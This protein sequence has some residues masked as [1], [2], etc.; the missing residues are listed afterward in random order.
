MEGLPCY[1]YTFGVYKIVKMAN[2][3]EEGKSSIQGLT[4]Y[5]KILNILIT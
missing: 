1:E 5:L 4:M 3:I 2:Q